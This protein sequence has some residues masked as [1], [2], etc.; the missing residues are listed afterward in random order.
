MT[1]DT[2]YLKKV[3]S[4][5]LQLAI[6][7]DLIQNIFPQLLLTFFHYSKKIN[8]GKLYKTTQDNI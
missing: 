6:H 3:L 8:K 5:F 2:K 1:Y 4:F 7:L